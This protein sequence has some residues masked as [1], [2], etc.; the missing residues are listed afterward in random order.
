MSISKCIVRLKG[1]CLSRTV[2]PVVSFSHHHDVLGKRLILDSADR[3]NHFLSRFENATVP[4]VGRNERNLGTVR[5]I[6]NSKP[7]HVNFLHHS[8]HLSVLPVQPCSLSASRSAIGWARDFSIHC[9]FPPAASPGTPFAVSMGM[10][11]CAGSRAATTALLKTLPIGMCRNRCLRDFSM[12]SDSRLAG[13][14]HSST[15]TTSWRPTANFV[16]S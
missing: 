8:S 2:K 1:N 12:G 4:N 5:A 10:E 6:N 3:E 7:L 9:S 11:N 14:S 13:F 16:L 15:R